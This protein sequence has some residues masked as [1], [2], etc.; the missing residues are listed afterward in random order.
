MRIVL[1]DFDGTIVDSM[2]VAMATYNQIAPRY[3]LTPITPEAL[4]RLR[5]LSART[6]MREHGVTFWKL[7]FIMRSMRRALH[8]QVD[9]LEAF[10][11]MDGALRALAGKRYELGILSSNSTRN[12]QRFLARSQLQ[13]FAHIEGGSSMLGK[14]RALRKLM[15]AKKLDPSSVLYVGDEVRDVEA[16]H[17]AGVHSVAVSWGYA[18]RSALAARRPTHLVD[19]PEDLVALL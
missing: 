9:Q 17:E 18:D 14:A 1:F 3:G 7:P 12:I 13:L 4:P 6:A 5:T 19:R 11:G 16:A 2:A 10:P 15:K 8:E